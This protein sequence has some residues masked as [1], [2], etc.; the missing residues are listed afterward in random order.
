MTASVAQRA[1]AFWTW[2]ILSD[3]A[4][5]GRGSTAYGDLPGR[6]TYT[7]LA[8]RVGG[9]AVEIGPNVLEL[10]AS[11]C[12]ERNLPP[13]TGLVVS[14]ATGKPSD[15]FRQPDRIPAI[16]TFRWERVANPFA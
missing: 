8:R 5:R 6:I 12:E 1:R 15:G 9:A 11:D 16:Y 14:K 3:L 7:E 2:L 13:L 10:I 4:S